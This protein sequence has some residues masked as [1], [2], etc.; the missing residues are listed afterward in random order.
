MNL[1]EP[2]DH[3]YAP[4][5]YLRNF[6]VDEKQKRIATLAKHGE[7]AIWQERSI[8]EI[9]YEV[10]FYV[11]TEHGVPVCVETDINRRIETPISES[12]TWEKIATGRTD[13]LDQADRPVLYALVRHLEARTPHYLASM[14]ELAEMAADPDSE[15]PFTEEERAHYAELRAT[16]GLDR[17]ML[18]HMASTT[19]WAAESYR[20]SQLV[21]MRSPIPLRAST[22][23]VLA[24]RAPAHAAAALPLPGMVPYQLML[25][26]NP[27]AAVLLVL[28]DFEGA[29]A[30]L[31]VD[32]LTAEGWNR[33]YLGQFTHFNQV[34]HLITDRSELLA[35]ME[36]AG[37]DLLAE[38]DSKMSFRQR[39]KSG[40]G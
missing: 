38:S 1:N 19:E 28:G 37:Y 22:T 27:T 23:P 24:S 11:H 35:D 4:Q 8:K 21:V 17:A 2:H 20:S 3:H 15:I 32:V 36:W 18:N 12:P 7:R 40:G 26:L 29:F 34:R 6:A 31:E 14:N 5:F 13:L 25:T 9:G 30:N 16:P 33:R 39:A 10:D